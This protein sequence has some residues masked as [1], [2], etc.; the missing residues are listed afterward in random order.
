MCR[1]FIA[2]QLPAHCFFVHAG[3]AVVVTALEHRRHNICS[4]D[5]FIFPSSYFR[6]SNSYFVSVPLMLYKRRGD[7]MNMYRDV[8][9]QLYER[10]CIGE[11]TWR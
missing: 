11:I 3:Q 9:Q 8:L 5:S 10:I 1:C 4:L 2:E 6:E 7:E